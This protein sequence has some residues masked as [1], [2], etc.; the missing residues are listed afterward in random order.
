MSALAAALRQTGV[1]ALK[2]GRL[3]EAVEALLKAAEADPESFETWSYLGAAYSHLSDYE[4][5]R[6][7]FGRAIQLNVQSPRAWYN[8]GVAHQMAGDEDSA[9]TCFERALALDPSHQAAQEALAKLAPKPVSMSELASAGGK[10]RLP[11]AHAESLQDEQQS[12]PAEPKRPLTPQEIARLATPEGSF[13]MPGAQASE[14][15]DA[16]ASEDSANKETP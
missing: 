15:G 8:L 1:A 13:H 4:N 3:R 2:A 12:A 11:G 6:K 10:I 16:P 9:R 5:A 14:L 7:A